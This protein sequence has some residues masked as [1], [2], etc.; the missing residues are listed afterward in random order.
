MVINSELGNTI[1]VNQKCEVYQ[2]HNGRSQLP[3]SKTLLSGHTLLYSQPRHVLH[4]SGEHTVGSPLEVINCKGL[5][6][7]LPSG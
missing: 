4:P 5:G 1:I 6:V 3:S 7:R 2:K